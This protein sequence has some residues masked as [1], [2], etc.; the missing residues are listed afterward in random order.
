MGDLEEAKEEA[1]EEMFPDFEIDMYSFH[2]IGMS[3]PEAKDDCIR[4]GGDL[5]SIMSEQ[6]N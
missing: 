6:D 2:K 1:F 3:Q 4:R 5:V